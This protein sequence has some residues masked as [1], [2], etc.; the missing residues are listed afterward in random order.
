M[1]TKTIFKQKTL[2]SF[3]MLMIFGLFSLNISTAQSINPDNWEFEDFESGFNPETVITWGP[4][5]EV[6][7]VFLDFDEEELDLDFN[8]YNND[9]TTANMT[10]ILPSKSN[11]SIKNTPL[12]IYGYVEFDAGSPAEFSITILNPDWIVIIWIYDQDDLSDIENAAVYIYE[13][14]ATFFTNQN[15][16]IEIELD[17]GEYTLD[18]SANGYYDV[19]NHTINVFHDIGGVDF[20]IPM[21]RIPQSNPHVMSSNPETGENGVDVNSNIYLYFDRDIAEGNTGTAFD[22]IQL[23]DQYDNYWQVNQIQIE[24]GNTLA[25]YPEHPLNYGMTYTLRVP[26]Y[27][28]V[29]D[30]DHGNQMAHDYF[31]SFT[32]DDGMYYHPWIEPYNQYFSFGEPED[33]VFNIHWGSEDNINQVVW[34]WW[35]DEYEYQETILT[36]GVE[37]DVLGDELIFYETFLLDANPDMDTDERLEFIVEFSE[38]A[39]GYIEIRYIQSFKPSV[40]PNEL[41]YDI[42]NPDFLNSNIVYASAEYVVE[43]RDSEGPIS[44]YQIIGTWLIIEENF[45]STN[46]TQVSDEIELTIEFDTGDEAQ[47]NISAIQSGITG[48]VINPIF[49]DV[50]GNDPEEYI[51][52][53]ITWNDASEVTE[54]YVYFAEQW[55]VWSFEYPYYEVIPID[56]NTATLRI[57]IGEGDDDDKMT[58]AIEENFITIVVNFDIGSPKYVLLRWTYEYYEVIVEQVPWHGGWVDGAW[59]HGVGQEVELTAYPDDD[60]QFVKWVLEDDT[61]ITDNPYIFEMPN[62]DVYITAYFLADFLEVI[63]TDPHWEQQNVDVNSNIYIK[64]NREIAE[65]TEDN[66]FDDIIFETGIGMHLERNIYIQGG[67]VLVIEPEHTMQEHL[68]HNVIIPENAVVEAGNSDNY[69]EHGYF[70]RFTTGAYEYFAPSINPNQQL[71]S[72]M[73]PDAVDFII[74]WGSETY[75]NEVYHF[76]WEEDDMHFV[77][78][79]EGEDFFVNGDI[80]TIA[81]DFILGLNPELY[82]NLGFNVNFGSG[83]DIAVYVIVIPTT[84]PYINPST[85]IYDL[86]NPGDVNTSIVYMTAEELVSVSNGANTLVAGTDYTLTGSWLFIKNSYLSNE[87]NAIDDEIELTLL[88]D[89]SDE[90]EFT[91]TAVETGIENASINPTELTIYGAEAPEYVDLTITWNDASE[92]EDLYVIVV[93]GGYSE[94]FPYD[95]YE[96]TPIDSETSNLRVYLGGDK[97]IQYIYVTIIINFDIGGPANFY[98]TIIDEYYEV[99]ANVVPE[100]AGWVDGAWSYDPGEE[101]TLTAHSLGSLIFQNWRIDGV[102]VSTDNPYSFEMPNEDVNITAHF[103]EEGAETYILSLLVEP[104]GAGIVSGGGEFLYEES[105]TISATE[106]TGWAF[107]NWSTPDETVVSENNPYIFDMPEDDLTL[108]ANF[109]DVSNVEINNAEQFNIYPNPFS[110][111]LYFDNAN[112]INRVM[113]ANL[114]GQIV[115]ETQFTGQEYINTFSL[116]KGFYMI[117]VENHKGERFVRKLVKQ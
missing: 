115:S 99:I 89:T 77:N 43:V 52:V 14:E 86:S 97:N 108:I 38:F 58:K 82:D 19:N 10:I 65:G 44:E 25:I 7:R 37:Y 74:D 60:Y 106:N 42:S 17:E 111:I 117:I 96:V 46:L 90:V 34:Q 110:D 31:L 45:L 64:F 80:L 28:V 41:V 113:F 66:G 102:V 11:N 50:D 39:H 83:Y 6:E 98:L 101:V 93:S 36:E 107:V 62:Q 3:L 1:K 112:E 4:A 48:A 79:D 78:M 35:D 61:E 95:E 85:A 103:I 20:D 15:G 76:F 16:E 18:V 12:T 54:M 21:D 67:N 53:V 29:D 23:Q 40:Y 70:L 9:G 68:M 32:T 30:A 84:K 5:T 47:L 116:P 94:E 114:A 88:F 55:E 100:D 71:F 72:L 57:P 69:L 92:V 2:M 27:A 59:N 8:V 63:E 87:L 22:D 105:V 33:I 91:I 104:E 56:A 26:D 73:E 24:G 49:V 51:D 81:G 109:I 13:L 75:I